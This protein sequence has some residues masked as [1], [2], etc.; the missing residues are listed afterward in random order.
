MRFL[1]VLL[2]PVI[3]IFAQSSQPPIAEFSH[4]ITSAQFSYENGFILTEDGSLIAK[5]TSNSLNSATM[6]IPG[7][8]GG[9]FLAIGIKANGNF[10]SPG[11]LDFVLRLDDEVIRLNAY[12]ESDPASIKS[13]I[14][15]PLYFAKPGKFNYSLQVNVNRQDIEI[16]DIEV[17]FIDPG[18]SNPISPISVENT[19]DTYPKPPVVTRTQ[20]GCPQGQ[21]S[22]WGPSYTT[23]T[24]LIIHHT[25]DNNNVTDWP[26]A[27][28]AIWQYHT[29]SNGWG[30]VGYN[31]LV[32]PNG[33]IYE[34]RAGGDN[35]VG[36]H[37]CGTNGGTMGVSMLGTYTTVSPSAALQ[38]SL[39]KIL[40]WKADQRGINPLG[41]SFHGSSGLTINN[42]SGHRAGCAT[43]CPGQRFVDIDLPN[44]RQGVLSL[45]QSIAPKITS[46]TPENGTNDV[47][48]FKPI[49]LTFNLLM[50]TN[51]V[52]NAISISPI[53]TFLVSF[54]SISEA[55]I[56][57]VGLWSFNTTYTLK[58]DTTAKN[59]YGTPLDGDGN[60][61]AGDPFYLSFSTSQPDNNP[62]VIIKY[63]P[64]GV[65]VGTYAEM[66]IV[67]DEE[68]TNFDQNITLTDGITPSIPLSNLNF[69]WDGNRGLLTFKTTQLLVGGKNYLLKLKSNISD[70]VGNKLP[71]DFDISFY[72]PLVNLV[73][74]TVFDRF[75]GISTWQDPLDNLNTTG[76]DTTKTFFNITSE[77]KRGGVFSGRLEFGFSGDTGGKIYLAKS[78]GHLL[79]SG[80]VNT[81][82]WV[83][84]NLSG[85]KF[86]MLFKNTS[87]QL[88][89]MG[90]MNFYG[91]KFFNVPFQNALNNTEFKGFVVEQIESAELNSV[92]YFDNL[93]FNTSVTDVEDNTPGTPKEFELAQNYP[94]P[95]NPETRITFTIPSSM[96]V[97][98][99]VYDMMGSEVVTLIKNEMQGGSHS[100]IFNSSNLASG[101]YLFKLTAGIE[102]KTIKMILTK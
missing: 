88:V 36:A 1:F 93:Q 8:N 77:K 53:D 35:V 59:I 39:G 20:W 33:V 31:Y 9:Q 62:P 11:D 75:E 90:T 71:Q 94:N 56:T 69:K 66:M 98:G 44:V 100:V 18:K 23:V 102:S 16:K 63:F 57:P 17:I 97:T 78:T 4:V 92:I 64:N 58:V 29:F 43:D 37:F 19:E 5:G 99:K 82:V 32:D 68:I 51:S 74:G 85:N 47:K 67:F 15:T 41:S 81:G 26:A 40:A 54:P 30:D 14:L 70:K 55:V 21:S 83:F 95:F 65:D 61:V 2:I 38:A 48:V 28:R 34:G 50:D 49:T 86:G 45:I 73:E 76:A 60:G 24:H 101:I 42:I 13:A 27:V 79:P 6:R 12:E 52:R 46:F 25:D 84:G 72:V 22:G 96:F 7:M 87:E 91:W 10:V 89:E 80:S 3:S